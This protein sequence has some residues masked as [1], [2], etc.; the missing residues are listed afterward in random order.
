MY[1]KGKPTAL[2]DPNGMNAWIPPTD[3]SGNW[4]AKK[5]DSPGSLAR[6]AHITQAEAET[7]V[8]SANQARGQARTSE[9][10]VYKDDVVNVASRPGYTWSSGSQGKGSSGNSS[11]SSTSPKSAPNQNATSNTTNNTVQIINTISNIAGTTAGIVK[12]VAQIPA[13]GYA[14]AFSPTLLK[15][16]NYLKPISNWT[17]VLSVGTDV[18]LSINHQQPWTETGLNTAVTA[19]AFGVGGWPGVGIQLDYQASK[20]YFKT[21]KEHPEWVLPASYHNYTH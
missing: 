17:M 16:L 10:M 21:A 8:G 13:V 12:E 11:T 6:D 4:T 20:L 7:A 18:L 14:I 3:G 5:G 15:E 1:V 2:V 19:V 9:T